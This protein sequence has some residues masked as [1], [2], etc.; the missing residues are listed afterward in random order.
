MGGRDQNRDE[1]HLP[2]QALGFRRVNLE[3][4]SIGEARASVPN[5]D[6]DKIEKIAGARLLSK[7][8]GSV[9]G[10]SDRDASWS[11]G[12]LFQSVYLA[13]HWLGKPQMEKKRGRAPGPKLA[14]Y[15]YITSSLGGS[16]SDSLAGTRADATSTSKKPGGGGGG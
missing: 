5:Y 2:A 14:P 8:V 7:A 15:T 10:N 1:F 13:S 4:R 12:Y 9:R 11:S 16:H 3:T 6:D